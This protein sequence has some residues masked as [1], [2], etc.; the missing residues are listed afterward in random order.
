MSKLRQNIITGEWV[1]ISPE[2]SQRPEDYVMASSAKR[3]IPLDCPFCVTNNNAYRFSIKEAETKNVYVIPN[4]YPAFS[5]ADGVIDEGDGFYQNSKALGGHEVI[6]LKDHEQDVYDDGVEITDELIGVY[7]DRY[8]FYDQDPTIEYTM[9]I[10]NH[11]PEAGASIDHP[12]SQLFASA[13]VPSYIQKEL[14]NTKAYFE[15]NKKCV[16]CEMNKVEKENN[17]R[18]VYENDEF[19]VFTVFAARFPFEMW[20]VPKKHQPQ[21]EK[22]SAETQLQLADAMRNVLQKLNKSLNFP[23]FNYWIHTLPHHEA[24][25][26]E[27]YHWH[28][29]IAPRISKFGGYEMGSGVVIDVVSPEVAAEFLRKA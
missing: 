17:H 10:H 13:I 29:E 26:S 28:V 2:R 16:F 21:F 7:R 1:V 15:A 23:P 14:E 8:N 3:G 18:V 6:I 27:Y 22:I 20:V 9:L 11:G 19:I 24:G 25:A 12:H 5:K 4:K